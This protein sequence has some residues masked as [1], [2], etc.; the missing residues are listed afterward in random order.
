MP[1]RED[2]SGVCHQR[3]DHDGRWGVP[4]PP[5]EPTR[6]WAQSPCRVSDYDARRRAREGLR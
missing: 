2:R 4:H 3:G 1:P 5:V 6:V